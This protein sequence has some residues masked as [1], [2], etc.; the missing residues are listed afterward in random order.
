[1]KIRTAGRGCNGTREAWRR[2]GFRCFSV[3]GGNVGRVH[4]AGKIPY[5][6]CVLLP[7]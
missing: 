2:Q 3:L 5:K 4:V 1:M 7:I 6:L